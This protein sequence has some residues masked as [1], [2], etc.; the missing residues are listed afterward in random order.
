MQFTVTDAIEV[1][2]PLERCFAL[3]T[4]VEL[5]RETLGMQMVGGVTSGHVQAGSRVVWKGWKFGL[6]A[7]HHTL[8]TKFAAPHA[9]TVGD[10]ATEFDGQ[11]VAWFEDSQEKG[12]FATFRHIHLFRQ[13]ADVV[14]L[15]DTVW[16][17]LP[18]GP[19]GALAGRAIVAPHVRKLVRQ[20]FGLLKGLAEGEG[21]REYIAEP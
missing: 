13:R 17:S 16:F 8:I 11:P 15:E 6:P 3:S 9:G 21:W 2:A 14:Q 18:F 1:K 12:R 5:V 19:L 7:E 10:E 4:R 20:R